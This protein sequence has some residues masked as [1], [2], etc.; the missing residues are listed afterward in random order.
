MFSGVGVAEGVG[1][2]AVMEGLGEERVSV[3]GAGYASGL[4]AVAVGGVSAWVEVADGE[5]VG[6]VALKE[7]T[8]DGTTVG[9]RNLWTN[10]LVR[11][12]QQIPRIETNPITIGI[13]SVRSNEGRGCIPEK[14][15]PRFYPPL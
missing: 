4:V 12:I 14:V 13:N 15:L 10:L 8:L 3:A 11:N 6:V 5:G 9:G 2:L 7:L 1:G